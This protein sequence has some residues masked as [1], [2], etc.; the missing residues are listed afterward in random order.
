M[1]ERKRDAYTDTHQR[2]TCPD[3]RK[4]DDVPV[5]IRTIIEAVLPRLCVLCRQP[6]PG[7]LC[8]GCNADL[9]R[10]SRACHRCG[11]SLPGLA[12]PLVSEPLCGLCIRRPPVFD[13]TVAALEYEFPAPV[14][15]QGFKY[16]RNMAFGAVLSQLMIEALER[17][18]G[19]KPP[20]DALVPVP[21]HPMRQFRRVFNQADV[22][23]RDLGRTLD[24]P[25]IANT[26]WRTR[27][28][29][30]QSGLSALNR[31][32]NLR[33]AFACRR[34]PPGKVALVDDVLTT[35]ATVSECARVLKRAGTKWVAVWVA[36]RA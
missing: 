15:V 28:T 16:R 27:R 5:T 23:A 2:L 32:K 1:S 6:S 30:P 34:Q 7:N 29:P 20:L 22:L 3:E 8:D 26:L 4:A 33:G 9:P 25:V 12:E 18:Y 31:R 24:I 11:I 14:L 35:G 10:L 21:L 36:A 17:E 13:R 19:G